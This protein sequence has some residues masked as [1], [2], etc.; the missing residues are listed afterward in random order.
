MASMPTELVAKEKVRQSRVRDRRVSEDQM[1]DVQEM[2][3][4]KHNR[5]SRRGPIVSEWRN[6]ST[7]Q[8]R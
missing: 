7:S 6:A 2:N 3:A 5:S 1:R 4:R 8:S